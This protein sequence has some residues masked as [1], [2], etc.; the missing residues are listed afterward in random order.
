MAFTQNDFQRFVVELNRTLKVFSPASKGIPPETYTAWQSVVEAHT[1]EDV[2]TVLNEWSIS[3]KRMILP[4]DMQELLAKRISD[5]VESQALQW[6]NREMESWKKPSPEAV[7]VLQHITEKLR[8]SNANDSLRWAKVLRIKEAYGFTLYP[9]CREF[10]RRALG[11][12]TS[13]NF[14]DEK[15]A[16]LPVRTGKVPSLQPTDFVTRYTAKNGTVL[17]LDP[18]FC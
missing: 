17:V 2:C 3:K 1:L 6:K 18:E 15:Y 4:S 12:E 5:R 16:R 8:E 9:I 11:F 14:D 7:L 13:F 10:W